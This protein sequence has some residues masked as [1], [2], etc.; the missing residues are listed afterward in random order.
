MTASEV[1]KRSNSV[2][3]EMSQ[4]PMASHQPQKQPPTTTTR[5]FKSSSSYN[6]SSYKS[7]TMKTLPEC[8]S[9]SGVQ[10]SGT[11]NLSRKWSCGVSIS[12]NESSNDFEKFFRSS[13]SSSNNGVTMDIS[14]SPVKPTSDEIFQVSQVDY[15]INEGNLDEGVAE[16]VVV[17]SEHAVPLLCN[18]NDNVQLSTVDTGSKVLFNI[19]P[20]E[21]SRTTEKL[22]KKI[23]LSDYRKM[24]RHNSQ[25][26]ERKVSSESD[27]ACFFDHTVTEDHNYFYKPPKFEIVRK[28]STQNDLKMY[29]SVKIG[30]LMETKT[31]FE[32][33]TQVRCK[34][35]KN[36]LVKNQ[37]KT[38]NEAIKDLDRVKLENIAECKKEY[39]TDA[40]F[41]NDEIKFIDSKPISEVRHLSR[42]DLRNSQNPSRSFCP[43][44][45]QQY[46]SPNATHN[47]DRSTKKPHH[48]SPST[49]KFFNQSPNSATKHHSRSPS[50]SSNSRSPSLSSRD[51][52]T[53]SI[54][55]FTSRSPSRSSSGSYC[56]S[57][58]SSRSSSRSS[59]RSYS[60]DVS[61]SSAS[62]FSVYRCVFNL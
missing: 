57:R 16:N 36:F 3:T 24:S 53:L 62:S 23:S 9:F 61:Y 56:I 39:I 60:S 40:S 58:C 17:S 37:L 48:K 29:D 34:K 32:R 19:N 30:N 43:T 33:I 1:L 7:A 45:P 35:E 21:T 11:L 13:P 14:L 15:K 47:Y 49:L 28:N 18:F 42:R 2:V 8:V 38:N 55:S 12:N 25:N 59:L 5:F 22:K 52:S 41:N 46:R 31:E 20:V 4:E 51:S 27:L 10:G 50:S 54:S 26:V 6:L 44:K